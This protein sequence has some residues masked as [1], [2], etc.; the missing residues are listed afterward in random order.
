MQ[1]TINKHQEKK[2]REDACEWI[3]RTIFKNALPFNIVPSKSG[4]QMLE[5]FGKQRPNLKEPTYEIG[6]NIC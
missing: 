4:N 1:S 5:V 2:A 6:E 3:A